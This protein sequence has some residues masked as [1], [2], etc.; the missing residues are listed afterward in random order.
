MSEESLRFDM[1]VGDKESIAESNITEQIKGLV[2]NIS[3]AFRELLQQI[4]LSLIHI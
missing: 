1:G 2:R 4:K 3:Q